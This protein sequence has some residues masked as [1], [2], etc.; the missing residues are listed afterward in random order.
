MEFT[1]I[2]IKS[3][4]VGIIIIAI[5]CMFL[6]FSERHNANLSDI[7]FGTIFGIGLI[8]LFGWNKLID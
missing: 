3:Q 7:I 8:T 5:A 6:Y 4:I 2:E 1:K